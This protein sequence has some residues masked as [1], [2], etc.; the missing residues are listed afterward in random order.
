MRGST[1]RIARLPSTLVAGL[2]E[3]SERPIFFSKSCVYRRE[4]I[5]RNVTLARASHLGY[6]NMIEPII[7]I[8]RN[9]APPF[10]LKHEKTA[11]RTDQAA[12]LAHHRICFVRPALVPNQPPL[13]NPRSPPSLPGMS[14]AARFIGQGPVSKAAEAQSGERKPRPGLD[15]R[16]DR[17]YVPPSG[18][19]LAGL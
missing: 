1:L 12:A 8:I 4:P 18:S 7:L 2:L 16:S 14:F 9:P 15:M 19:L 17:P 11:L 10:F 3:P 13:T 5:C 6:T